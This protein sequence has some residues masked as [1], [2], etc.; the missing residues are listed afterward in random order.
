[1]NKTLGLAGN[2]M[3]GKD[4][5]FKILQQYLTIERVAF[6]DEL[7]HAVKD[8]CWSLYKID[9]FTNNPELKEIIRPTLVVVGNT[10]RRVN[11]RAWIDKAFPKVQDIHARGNIACI[12]DV[13]FDA[14]PSDEVD[15]IKSELGGVLVYIE[16]LMPN[17]ILLQPANESEAQNNPQIK[18]KADI[19]LRA[20]NLQELEVQ[21]LEQVLPLLSSIPDVTHE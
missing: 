4:S 2:A 7:K 9:S 3:S 1:M 16:R 13:R 21:L 19:C 6:A 15:F 8:L 18:A 14:N 12:T 20:S 5:A 17:G 11:P 10:V